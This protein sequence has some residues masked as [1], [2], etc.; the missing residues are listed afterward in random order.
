M[1]RYRVPLIAAILATLFMAVL[2]QPVS[3]ADTPLPTADIPNSA[4]SPLLKRYE[5]SFIVS[6]ESFA[7]TDFSIP[8]STLEL[9]KERKREPA[10]NNLIYK[11][12]KS[13][14]VEGALSRI[15]YVLPAERSPLEVLRNFQDEVVKAGG[16]TLWECKQETC[17][18]DLGRASNGGGGE[19]SL[20]MYFFHA[21][22]LKDK[23]DSSGLCALT[24]GVSDQRFFAGKIPQTDGDTY[25]T[26]QT[27]SMPDSRGCK[28]F[29]GRTVALVH[30]LEPKARD[31]KMV[32]VQAAEMANDLST[33]GRVAL[34]GI[35]FDTDKTELKPES[36]ATLDEIATLLK[37]SPK[38]AVLVVGHTDNQ[39][40]FD[41]NA[42]LST[43]RASVLSRSS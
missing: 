30:V 17:G 7:Y 14:D 6:T 34:Y 35:Y 39:G 20:M 23:P 4:D 36:K 24:T 18:G 22:D 16:E 31:K 1:M 37:D 9:D 40:K 8:L 3:A 33:S 38:L 15:A 25:V 43:R 13:L 26:V 29:T 21:A 32:V 19:M 2:N 11:P 41:Y 12:E 5:G 10:H 42:D 28:A 27:F